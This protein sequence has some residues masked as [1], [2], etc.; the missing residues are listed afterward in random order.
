MNKPKAQRVPTAELKSVLEILAADEIAGLEEA[1]GQIETMLDAGIRHS[2]NA[3]VE[4]Y[5]TQWLTIGRCFA[6]ATK[7]DSFGEF[8]KLFSILVHRMLR[9]EARLD[10]IEMALPI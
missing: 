6:Y 8:E 2:R 4:R 5:L 3:D 1:G 9:A 7:D 10:K